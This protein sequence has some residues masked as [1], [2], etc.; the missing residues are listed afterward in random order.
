MK[1]EGKKYFT[2]DLLIFLF[3]AGALATSF[4]IAQIKVYA[5]KGEV[6]ALYEE[7]T[8]IAEKNRKKALSENE[9]I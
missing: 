1:A 2:R 6:R 9:H 4:M 8:T 3:I 7:K 5:I